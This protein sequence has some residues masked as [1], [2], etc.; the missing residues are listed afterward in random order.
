MLA[1][2]IYDS[3]HI[4]NFNEQHNQYLPVYSWATISEFKDRIPI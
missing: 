3:C 2:T 4:W 1:Y